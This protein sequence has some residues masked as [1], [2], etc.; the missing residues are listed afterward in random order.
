MDLNNGPVTINLDDGSSGSGL[1]IF[2]C[3]YTTE[4]MYLTIEMQGGTGETYTQPAGIA[5]PSGGLFYPGGR[6]GYGRLDIMTKANREFTIAGLFSG[7]NTPFLYYKQYLIAVVGEGGQGGCFGQG[8]QGGGMSQGGYGYKGEGPKGGE[9]GGSSRGKFGTANGGAG[10][11]AGRQS[12]PPGTG[13]SDSSIC[14]TGAAACT[15]ISNVGWIGGHASSVG[16]QFSHLACDSNQNRFCDG[17][18]SGSYGGRTKATSKNNINGRSDSGYRGIDR[19]IKMRDGTILNNTATIARGFADIEGAF[20]ATA[21]AR[22]SAH[23]NDGL[24]GRG[25]N[26]AMGG[27]GSAGGKGGGGGSGFL[28]D[29]AYNPNIGIKEHDGVKFFKR[30]DTGK[31]DDEG[32]KVK[33]TLDT[34]EMGTK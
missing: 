21:G 3:F 11:P 10:A 2:T 22:R 18:M 6:G 29:M 16:L 8:G 24:G 27:E 30:A 13:G 5:M 15:Y 9:N 7:I 12:Y 23:V 20:L 28:A 31:I 19:K 25:G 14:Q 32:A 33:I 1:N 34:T 17:I 4:D 26:G